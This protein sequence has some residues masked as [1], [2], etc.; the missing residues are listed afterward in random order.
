[1]KFIILSFIAVILSSVPLF[2]SWDTN[3]VTGVLD[4]SISTNIN[5]LDSKSV[6]EL[7]QAEIV[8]RNAFTVVEREQIE[9][10]IEE[11][12]LEMSGLTESEQAQS[13]GNLLGAD[14]IITGS[15]SKIGNSY[16]VIIKGINTK[17]GVVEYSDENSFISM[18]NLQKSLQEVADRFVNDTQGIKSTGVT[19]N[20]IITNNNITNRSN[21]NNDLDKLQVM[22]NNNEFLKNSN[23]PEM[24]DYSGEIPYDFRDAI[25]QKHRKGDFWPIFGNIF[26]PSLGSFCQGDFTGGLISGFGVYGSAFMS[27]KSNSSTWGTLAGAFY[28]YGIIEPALFAG[29]WNSKLKSSLLLSQLQFRQDNS[30]YSFN[31]EAKSV[32]FTVCI[33]QDKF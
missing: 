4:F 26:I 21:S 9:R 11:K 16:F 24:M 29:N 18:D 1:M 25:Y 32:S 17:N 22:I 8:H 6:S 20:I 14:K 10:I 28:I 30:L 7:V 3:T 19:D 23:I 15:I 13:I 2:A 12:K 33:F 5:D 27:S 31:N